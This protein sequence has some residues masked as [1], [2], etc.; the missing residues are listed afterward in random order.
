MGTCKVALTV[1]H[2]LTGCLNGQNL[3]I[4]WDL[5][6][7]EASPHINTILEHIKTKICTT[8]STINTLIRTSKY[9][10]IMC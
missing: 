9:L 4:T 7:T 10:L 8:K 3:N 2:I 6:L 1:N 5:L